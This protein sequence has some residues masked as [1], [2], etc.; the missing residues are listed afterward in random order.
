VA[1]WKQDNQG[2][3]LRYD[4]DY[5]LRSGNDKG[6]VCFLKKDKKTLRFPVLPAETKYEYSQLSPKDRNIV[7]FMY[8]DATYEDVV[9]YLIINLSQIFM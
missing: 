6:K 2:D 5:C 4:C 7:E 3:S 1:H 9:D 8:K